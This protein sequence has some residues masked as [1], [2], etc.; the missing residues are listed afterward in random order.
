[1]PKFRGDSDDWLDQEG[2]KS[3]RRGGSA[4]KN[5]P[6]GRAIDLPV[7]KA[8]AVVAEIF[9]NQCRVRMDGS[10]LALLC[11][12][13]RAGVVGKSSTEVRE[14]TPVAVGDRVFVQSTGSH[15]GII[16]GICLRKNSLSRPAPGR[17]EGSLYHTLAANI[18]LLVIVVSVCEPNF[19]SGLVD[20]F[21]VAAESEKIPVV[22][23]LTKID[24]K[25]G[26]ET[27]WKIYEELGYSVLL[28]SSKDRTGVTQM[29]QAI[30]G[31]T[32]VFCGQS[33]VGKTSLL[34]VLLDDPTLGK[35]GAVNPTTG[36]GRHTTTG[37][38]LVGDAHDSRWIDT[39]GVRE[40]GLTR[41]PA[42]ELSRYF[43]E[44]QNIH[45]VE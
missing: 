36:K 19:S 5:K 4:G 2:T 38:V 23:G 31:K 25:V 12:Y 37:A 42:N 13:R 6:V 17:E 21:L 15:T 1:M 8:N 35:I 22:I 34:R 39:P 11:S 41:I 7:E 45:Q 9:P 44:M 18:D 20:R 43:L 30:Q 10:A 27:P 14:R 33:G 24:L 40:F 26:E 16:E 32:V 29:M 3:K 28:L